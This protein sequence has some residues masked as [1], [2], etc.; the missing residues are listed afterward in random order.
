MIF[1]SRP[2]P[3]VELPPSGGWQ[4]DSLPRCIMHLATRLEELSP[5]QSASLLR[6]FLT[7]ALLMGAC[8]AN[9]APPASDT[10]LPSDTVGFVS[11]P[12]PADFRAKW[13]QTQLGQFTDQPALKPFVESAKSQLMRKFG[14][15]EERLGVTLNDLRDVAAGELA[16]GMIDRGSK[17]AVAVLLVDT[18]GNQGKRDEVIAK[19]EAHLGERRATR[20]TSQVAGIEIVRYAIP[21]DDATGSP[22]HASYFVHDK[23]LCVADEADTIDAIARRLTGSGEGQTLASRKTYAEVMQRAKSASQELS[24][25]LRWFVDPFRFAEASRTRGE[26]LPKD[27]DHLKDIR[28]QGFDAMQGLGGYVHVASTPKHDFVHRTF[29]YAPPAANADSGKKYR[30]AMNLLSLPNRQDL[31]LHDWTP[32]TIA[33]YTTVNIE[34]LNAF[35]H[36]GTLFDVFA[37]YEGAFDTAMEGYRTDPFG[38]QIDVRSQIIASLGSRVS[39]MTDYNLPVQVDSER[40]LAAVEVKPDKVDTLR[41]AIGKYLEADG[42][43]V[44]KVAGHEIWE[45]EPEEDLV[46]TGSGLIPDDA[47]EEEES[48]R[49]LTR[50]AVGIFNNTLF[51]ASDVDFLRVVFEPATLNESLAESFDVQDVQAA[52]AQLAPGERASWSFQRTDEQLRPTYELVRAGKM[53]ESETFLGRL[54]N[55][56]L[57]SAEDQK[58]QLL[59]EQKLDGSKLPTFEMARR[60]FGPAGRTI[61]SDEDGWLITGVVLNKGVE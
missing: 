45:F 55:E 34:L 41:V 30:L 46:T 18:T 38:P 52:L 11:I 42:F 12:N 23:L 50:S 15:V 53:P 3:A 26:T 24:D 6:G 29:L 7:I 17:R 48:V 60:Y 22:T 39:L 4:Y 9:A 36:V 54:L 19:I 57:T 21:A 33:R 28:E 61:R 59:R 10:L 2:A 1:P 47:E 16:W 20:S 44:K 49:L 37:G 32:R 51:V 35:D 5:V 25:D 14:N 58:N 56:L 40:F 27:K 31:E 8:G 43:I 13:D